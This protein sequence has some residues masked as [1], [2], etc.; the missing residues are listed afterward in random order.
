M[1]CAGL[2][3][4]RDAPSEAH[5][6]HTL[7]PGICERQGLP[8]HQREGGGPCHVSLG[9]GCRVAQW[10]GFG[11]WGWSRWMG[12]LSADSG[13]GVKSHLDR[14]LASTAPSS[15]SSPPGALSLPSSCPSDSTAFED[16]LISEC[17]LQLLEATYL[18]SPRNSRCPL[19]GESAWS[20]PPGGT[21]WARSLA[22]WSR[23]ARRG[24][25]LN[26]LPPGEQTQAVVVD[27]PRQRGWSEGA[28]RARSA[29]SGPPA[30]GF[31]EG[32]SVCISEAHSPARP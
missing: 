27:V 1:V 10:S 20:P 7:G 8:Q 3:Q 22:S 11:V 15:M 25:V 14:S 31:P 29:I 18:S 9:R 30:R 16:S 2:A 5:L 6:L 32:T 13:R 4:A 12:L 24:D 26:T 23:T 28:R 17:L 19:L 21:G